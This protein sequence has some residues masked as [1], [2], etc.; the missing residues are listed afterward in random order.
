MNTASVAV[1]ERLLP[2]LTAMLAWVTDNMPAIEA[3]IDGVFAAIGEAIDWFVANVVPPLTDAFT[4]VTDDVVPAL[5][6][7]IDWLTANILPPLQSIFETWAENVLPALQR[8][9][10][11]VQGW[12]SDN[13]PLIC[14]VVGQVAGF[15][16]SAMDAVAAV[17]KAVMPVITKVADVA[18]PLVGAAASVLLTVLSTAFD[19]I[20]TVWQT[21]WDVATSVTKGIGDAFAGLQRGI[22]LVWD[23]IT[24]IVKGAINILIDAVN[25]MIRALNGIQIHIPQVGVGDVA[26][27]PFDW[28][29][30]NLGTIPRLATGTR[31][32]GGGWA[33]LGERGPE[34]AR[35][36]RGTD[37]FTAA[38]SRD[39]LAGAVRPRRS[40]HRQ[41]DDLRRA[42]GRRRARDPP[43]AA[44][45]RPRLVARGRVAMATLVEWFPADGSA[46]AR[47]TTGAA[48]P[49]RLLRLEGTEPVTVEPV[50]VKSPNQPGATALDVVVPP[51]VVT[52]GGLLAGGHAGRRLG[53]ARRA[54][55]LA[56]PAADPPR[57]DVRPRPP[58]GDPRRPRSRSSSGRC[59][60]ARTSSARRAPRRSPRST[61]SGSRPS[62]TGGASPTPRCCS[63]APAASRSRSSSRSR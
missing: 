34:L 27:G 43:G 48:A 32:F 10:A 36:P 19:A 63:R 44:A 33:M 6:D 30:L 49:L 35:L 59:R 39:L 57:R 2:V 42:A 7:V 41:P 23:G 46:S 50:T 24:G 3:T 9:F 5:G 53:P 37:V 31:D 21:A 26:V 61:S 52:L 20:G 54:A 60:A 4:L 8:A 11:F 1:G 14:K 15:V 12:I 56:R 38:Q 13:W 51:R 58:A 18:F 47:F 55:A 29:G 45:S 17:F 22:K 28:N 40:A 16:K 25:G 62:R